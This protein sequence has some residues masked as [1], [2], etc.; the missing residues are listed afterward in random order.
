MVRVR[1]PNKC[2]HVGPVV[3]ISRA[4]SCCMLTV[5]AKTSPS[6][7]ACRPAAPGRPL[8]RHLTCLSAVQLNESISSP[9]SMSLAMARTMQKVTLFE[10]PKRR[11]AMAA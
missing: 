11:K 1:Y 2:I 5:T 8:L 7:V 3:L 6:H 4:G 10:M 9:F